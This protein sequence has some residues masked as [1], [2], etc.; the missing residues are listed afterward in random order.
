MR[1][2]ALTMVNLAVGA[3]IFGLPALTARERAILVALT[4][5]AAQYLGL[6]IVAQGVLGPALATAG[7]A[8]LEGLQ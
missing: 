3:G 2:L 4:L 7:D 6:Q 1:A 5:I 8:P